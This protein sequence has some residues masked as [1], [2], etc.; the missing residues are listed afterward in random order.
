M[1]IQAIMMM[2]NDIKRMQFVLENFFKWNPDIPVL[3]YNCGGLSPKQEV[4]QFKNAILIDYDDIWHKRGPNGIGSFDPRWFQLMF[5]YG[6]NS[7]YTH[8]LFLETDVLTTNKITKIPK[9]DM[10]GILNFCGQGEFILYQMLNLKVQQH[11][12][13][14]STI[15]RTE[16]FEK[17]KDNLELVNSLYMQRPQNFF[18]DLVMTILGRVSDCTYGHW[19]E[20]SDIRGHWEPNENGVLEFKIPPSHPATFIHSL[21]V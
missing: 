7:S 2:K 8:T 4:A 13:C 5:E 20:C 12:G 1:K 15:Y 17:C 6:L 9:Y 3:V 21:K 14:G 19:E 11:S 18:Q 16:F 10:S